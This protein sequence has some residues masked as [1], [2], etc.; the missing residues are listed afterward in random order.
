MTQQATIERELKL[1]AWPGFELPDLRGALNGIVPGAVQEWRLEAVYFDTSDLRLL[2]RG[3]TLRFRRGEEPGDLWTAKL[4][5]STPALGMSRREISVAAGPASMPTVLEDLV[6]GWA[7][8]APLAPVARLRTLRNRT[9]L[10]KPDGQAVAVVDDDEVSIIQRSRVAARFRELELELLDGASP[11]LMDRLSKRVRSAG[12]QPVEQI[13]K[14]VRAL[15]PSALAPWDLAPPQLSPTPTAAELLTA[16]LTRSAARLVDH[17]AVVVLDEDME[18]VHQSRVAIRTLRSDLRTAGPLLDKTAVEPLRRDLDWL[19]S[20]LGEVRDLD[21]LL[22]RLGEDIQRLEPADRP[23]ASLVLEQARQDRAAAYE[24]LRADLRTPRCA[25][26]LQETA[27]IAADPPLRSRRA[28]KPAPS[29]LPRLVRGPVEDLR[30]EVKKQGQTPDDDAMHRIRIRTK[31]ARYAAELA[32][33]ATTGKARK[34]A[35]KLAGVQDLLGDHHDACVAVLALRD[36]GARTGQSGAWACGLLG[37]LAVARAAEC[38][39]RFASVWRD[40]TAR[41]HWRWT[42]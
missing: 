26:L 28:R 8:G 40:A 31:R 7:L 2:R 17:I 33:P 38:R 24:R 18:G 12:A 27:L 4:P 22:A 9:T 36:L 10:R 6:R 42:G 15:G 16:A 11:K 19:M 30:R 1:G 39:T 32:A 20:S 35:R 21:V 13:P 23:A 37:G 14:L 34:S 5:E 41:K 29:V 25:A 3:V